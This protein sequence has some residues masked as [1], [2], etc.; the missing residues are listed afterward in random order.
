LDDHTTHMTGG[1][2]RQA[3]LLTA[4]I[5][6]V[7]FAA[8]LVSHSIALLADAGHILTD[9]FALG[10]A[11]F[12]VIQATRPA[13]LRRTYGYQRVG[14]LAA[15]ANAVTL[16]LIVIAITV[17]AVQRL[18][19]PQPV[20]GALVIVSALV[21]IAVN[22][23]IARGL[24]GDNKNLNVR[25]A[26]L[27]VLGDLAASIG[28]VVAG[29]VILLTG[30]LY[31]DPIVSILITALIGFGAWR[32]VVDA[33][34]VLLEGVP[35]GID[36]DEVRGVIAATAGV[37]SV[38]DLH[39]W[40]LSGE[41]IALSCHLVVPEGLT[42]DDS[43]HLVRALEQSLCARFDIGHTTIQ[44]ESCHPCAEDLP[45]GPDA[46]NHPHLRVAGKN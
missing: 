17:E 42:T 16:V 23:Y 1:R 24:R 27:H 38:H 32:I 33:V 26:L 18:L 29:A 13:D 44:V 2:L 35:E 30:W 37:D 6:L 14:I 10:L 45:H 46:H 43:E 20:N 34:N 21:A 19:H 15:G 36:L 7:E 40:S 31:A 3:F 28:V 5:L 4:F 25:A 22:V 11:W 39:V 41:S 9:V 8:G 12:A